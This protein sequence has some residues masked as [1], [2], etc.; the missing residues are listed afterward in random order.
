MIA[1]TWHG[2]TTASRSDEYLDYL[3]KTGIKDCRSTEGNRGVFVMRRV[4]EGR[5]EFLFISLWESFDA[6][7]KFAGADFETAVYY[8]ED[9]EFLLEL[10]PNVIHY[11]VL[12]KPEDL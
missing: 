5:A 4:L 12:V 2:V 11:E 9:K 3:K 6:I 1:R 10:E 8:P 7:R